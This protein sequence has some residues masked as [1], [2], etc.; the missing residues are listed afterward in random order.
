MKNPDTSLLTAALH[1]GVFF[2]LCATGKTSNCPLYSSMALV[3]TTTLQTFMTLF[4]YQM[5]VQL[6]TFCIQPIRAELLSEAGPAIDT[7]RLHVFL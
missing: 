2:R 5:I 3:V 4:P 7:R 6:Q 1:L